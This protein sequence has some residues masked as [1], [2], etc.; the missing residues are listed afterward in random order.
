MALGDWFRSKEDL[1]HELAERETDLSPLV[2]QVE[3][4]TELEKCAELYI[5]ESFSK[6]QIIEHLNSVRRLG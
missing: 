2:H 4:S 6:E 1:A 3:D 5:N